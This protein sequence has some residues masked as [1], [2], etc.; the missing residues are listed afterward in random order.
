MEKLSSDRMGP[1]F[2][3]K[4]SVRYQF[5]GREYESLRPTQFIRDHELRS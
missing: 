3:V 2:M 1:R 5:P 4:F